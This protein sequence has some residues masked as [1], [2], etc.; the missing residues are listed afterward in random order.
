MRIKLITSLAAIFGIFF[1][2]PISASAGEYFSPSGCE[3]SVTFP[4]RY[5]TKELT[6]PDGSTTILAANPSG[7]LTKLS[8]ECWPRGSIS[9]REYAKNLGTKFNDRGVQ[10]SSITLENN[11]NGEMVVFSGIAGEGAAKLH[12]RFISHFGQKTRLDLLIIDKKPVASAEHL[13]FRNSVQ[14]K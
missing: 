6:A 5:T 2:W 3:F 7:S 13:A 1:S 8:A 11:Q 14:S 12:L 10:T 4:G 9:A